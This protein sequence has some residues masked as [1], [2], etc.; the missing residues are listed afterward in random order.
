MANTTIEKAVAHPRRTEARAI[1]PA[2]LQDLK[3]TLKTTATAAE[4]VRIAKAFQR[5][6]TRRV[7][8]LAIVVVE[9]LAEAS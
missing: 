1:Q 8:Q 2:R 9:K 5:I 7:R 4:S 6:R 3:D